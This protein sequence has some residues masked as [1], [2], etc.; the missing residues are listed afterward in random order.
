MYSDLP[1]SYWDALQFCL[2]VGVEFNRRYGKN[3]QEWLLEP[4][5]DEHI[6]TVGLL[7][8]GVFVI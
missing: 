3:W 8:P 5:T 1:H 6:L 7:V 4:R 2:Y